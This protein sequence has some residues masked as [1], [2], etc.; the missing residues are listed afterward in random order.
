MSLFLIEVIIVFLAALYWSIPLIHAMQQLDTPR[1]R[2]IW[3][4]VFLGFVFLAPIIY[5]VVEYPSLR[6]QG[7][8]GLI[9]FGKND[10]A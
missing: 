2:T 5:L 3:L 6:R 9:R 1:K 4:L 8:G 10:V 7:R